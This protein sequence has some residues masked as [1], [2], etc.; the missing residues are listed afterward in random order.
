MQADLVIRGARVVNHDGEFMGG[1]AAQDG[2]IVALGPDAT[3]PDA[4]RVIEADGRVL[5]PGVVDP[6]C[7]LGFAFPYDEDVRTEMSAAAAG[8]VTTVLDYVQVLD[9]DWLGFYQSLRRQAEANAPVDFGYHFIIQRESH[10]AEIPA[11]VAATGI[12]SFK[13]YFGYEPD[14]PIGLVPA[15]DGWVYAAMRILAGIPGGIINVHCENTAIGTWLKR[16]MQ[17]LGRQDLAAFTESRPAF[18]EVETIRRMIFL[19][20]RTGCPL[21]LVHTSVGDGPVLAAES[22]GRGFD[23]TV[24]TCP[25][26][27]TRTCH[28]ADLDM[29]AKIMPPLRD[30]HEQEGLWR[31]LFDGS[32]CHLGTDHV[33]FQPKPGLN[34]WTEPPGVIGF[35]TELPLLLEFGVRQRGLPLTTLV[36]LNA[37]KPAK[38]FG[39]APKKGLI[40]LG[41]DADLVLV[42]LDL[43]KTVH[44]TGKGTGIYDGFKLRGWPV[45]TVAR[46]M[47]VA[48]D[49]VAD[50][51]ALGRGQCLTVPG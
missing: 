34:L 51:A 4:H 5:M 8:G 15:T 18:C 32:V 31:G 29:R 6:H 41:S 17:A 1:V 7:H 24:E 48:E 14:N 42:D 23:V 9:E 2:V 30:K 12:R 20:E 11:M 26:Y 38:R 27:L 43:E 50:P 47:V 46:G 28:D 21:H 13:F 3:L 33:P 39:L 19:A 40:A 45:L 49:G 22:Q 35:Q 25:H 37:Y 16:E 36:G 10:I 44:H